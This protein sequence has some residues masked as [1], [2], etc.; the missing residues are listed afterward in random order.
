M[1]VFPRWFTE[2][3]HCGQGL[4]HQYK[5]AIGEWGYYLSSE[6]TIRGKYA[7]QIERCWWSSLGKLNYLHKAP[8]S[9]KCFVFDKADDEQKQKPVLL[10]DRMNSD[11]NSLDVFKLDNQ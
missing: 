9:C 2:R 7:G 6:C 11:G 3:H 10:F 4:Q 5:Y 1:R 8:T